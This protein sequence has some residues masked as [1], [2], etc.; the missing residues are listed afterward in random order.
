M[1]IFVAGQR[2]Q[3]GFPLRGQL[4]A[5][6]LSHRK[7]LRKGIQ[8]LVYTNLW[9]SSGAVAFTCLLCS[10]VSLAPNYPLL[11]LI[12]FATLWTYTFQRWFKL[13]SGERTTGP[14]MEW[15]TA[16]PVAVKSVLV[17][18]LVGSVTLTYWLSALTIGLFALLGGIALFYVFKLKKS[19]FFRSSLREVPFVKILLISGV[20]GVSCAVIPSVEE[21]VVTNHL[22]PL[23][24]ATTAYIIAITI[25][26]DIRDVLLDEARQRTLP[27]MFGVGGAKAIALSC[28]A[29]SGWLWCDFL[30][31]FHEGIALGCLLS[32]GLILWATPQR[33][34]LFFSFFVDG[35]L[36]FVPLI[37]WTF[38]S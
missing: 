1:T 8:F 30:H 13:Q 37:G 27:Q 33:K 22:I 26:F 10:M 35:L 31:H 28:L 24:I 25:P 17:G 36:L 16:H 18:G 21:G 6:H 5:A 20:W 19:R 12:F 9:I 14:R 29:V 15:M 38:D 4:R 3:R 11:G 7:M 32:G 23:F 34:D 2:H